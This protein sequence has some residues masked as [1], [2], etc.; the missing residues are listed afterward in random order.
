MRHE[1]PWDRCPV[2]SRQVTHSPAIAGEGR[3]EQAADQTDQTAEETLAKMP[4]AGRGAVQLADDGEGGK[5][6]CRGWKPILFL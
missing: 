2:G 1:P 6:D 3:V 5:G 4:P